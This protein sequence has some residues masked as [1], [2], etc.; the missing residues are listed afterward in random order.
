M[1]ASKQVKVIVTLP[2]GSKVA[3]AL[4]K[5]DDF[6]V[7]LRD[8]EGQYRSFARTP[9]MK[10]EKQDPYAAHYEL[11]EQYTD[12]NIHDIVAYLESLK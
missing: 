8:A 4:D 9:D 2:S 7:S 1:A 10:V 3:G 6:N 11:L 12:K 5:I